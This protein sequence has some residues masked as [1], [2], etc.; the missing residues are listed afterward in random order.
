[1]NRAHEK[2]L[3]AS[4]AVE[5]LEIYDMY[6]LPQTSVEKLDE[7]R[8]WNEKERTGREK[9]GTTDRV[10]ETVRCG[11]GGKGVPPPHLIATHTVTFE[12]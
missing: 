8:R 1:M 6:A 4:G 10:E 11:K 2:R 3:A 5:V 9:G 7:G 12:L